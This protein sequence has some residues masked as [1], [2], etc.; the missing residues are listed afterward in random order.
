MLEK[1]GKRKSQSSEPNGQNQA[2]NKLQEGQ[3]KMKLTVP[4]LVL[5]IVSLLL[6]TGIVLTI[7]LDTSSRKVD[8]FDVGVD[9]IFIEKGRQRL[10]DQFMLWRQ[11][12]VSRYTTRFI[13]VVTDSQ[14]VEPIDELNVV[15]VPVPDQVTQIEHEKNLFTYLF[16]HVHDT[17][18][19]YFI[20]AGD[21]V[22]PMQKH[23]HPSTFQA[24]NTNLLRFFN[25]IQTDAVLLDVQDDFE[26]T[27]PCTLFSYDKLKDHDFSDMKLDFLL[28]YTPTYIFTTELDETIVLKK[29]TDVS[30]LQKRTTSARVFGVI[31]LSP[32]SQVQEELN[33]KVKEFIHQ[34]L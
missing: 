13:V 22:F 18:G 9:V 2:E 32:T 7:V 14:A 28:Q 31:H 6:F 29:T 30:R 12:W 21:N 16:D 19:R 25:G 17:Q 5:L 11:S 8:E 23:I 15:H 27:L 10:T 24:P 26:P 3:K 34:L 20:W 33:Q 4:Q 1:K